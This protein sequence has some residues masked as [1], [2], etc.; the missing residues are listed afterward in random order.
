VGLLDGLS[1]GALDALRR[2]ESLVERDLG[3]EE[4]TL[5]YVGGAPIATRG[6]ASL[7]EPAWSLTV[8]GLAIWQ[9]LV[10]R[11]AES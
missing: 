4:L 11:E 7:R 6:D 1:E 2:R 5:H 8:A 10:S 9:V 3:F